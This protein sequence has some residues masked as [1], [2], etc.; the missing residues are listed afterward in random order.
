MGKIS[1]RHFVFGLAAFIG[2]LTILPFLY[3]LAHTPPG[4]E[5]IGS[6]FNTDDHMVYAA[7]MRQS[8]DGHFLMDNRFAVDKQPGLTANVYFFLLGSVAKIVGIPW[9]SA[10]AR[11]LFGFL[12]VLLLERY[13]SR[14]TPQEGYRKLALLVVCFGAGLG[15]MAWQPLG[16]DFAADSAN[17]FKSLFLGHLPND[18]WQPEAFVFPSLL[19]N[20]L[21]AFSLCL[22]VGIL[23][24][25]LAA[26][27][28]WKSVAPGALG[29][30]VLMNVHSYDVLL[31]ALILLGLLVTAAVQRQ[32]TRAWFLRV[33]VIG[34][35]AVPAA[36]WFLHVLKSDP[37]FQARAETKTFTENFRSIFGGYILLILFAGI[38]G[39]IR[40]QSNPKS[41][42]LSA[43][44]GL[45]A[46]LLLSLFV[47][48]S[49]H[50]GDSYW[51]GV[52][53]WTLLTILG[54]AIIGLLSGGN[55]AI[56]LVISWAVIGLIVP[57]F[58]GLFERKLMMGLSVPW[59]ILAAGGVY[60]IGQ[61]L[62][63][64]ERRLVTA[65]CGVVLAAT[66]VRW[67]GRE[68]ELINKNDSTTTVNSVFLTP[69]E[70]NI[71]GYLT[72]RA[73][74]KALTAIALPGIPSSLTEVSTPVVSDF[75]P[76]LSGFAGAYTYAGHWSETPD[77]D[78]RRGQVTSFFF[79][80]NPGQ[81]VKFI[82]DVGIDYVIS[83]SPEKLASLAASLKGDV[84]LLRPKDLGPVVYQGKDLWLIQ[85]LPRS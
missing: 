71:L 30:L 53:G 10:L 43:G 38:G 85:T 46:I 73:G 69:D 14:I 31:L 35:G 9:A 61:R 44:L 32:L 58:P 41:K 48:A 11:L 57:Y 76:V 60:F 59:A 52:T 39:L 16:R 15:F 83:P 54:L 64:S 26:R 82:R 18:V 36:L 66:S 25:V 37:V 3:G 55:P 2:L 29:M 19:T 17:P 72:P 47:G 78:R 67:L 80:M 62:K 22:I 68:F 27:H 8:M 74:G 24:C 50:V 4:G 21:F 84:S 23:I 49:S 65:L 70:V 77:Y 20:S 28:T 33:F 51:M 56:N 34:I 81:R 75:N 5:Y 6:E 63:G 7:W 79:K 12:F 45:F 1:H 42:R 13:L 40:F